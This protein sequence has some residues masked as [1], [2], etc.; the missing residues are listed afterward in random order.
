MAE[1]EPSKWTY[2]QGN[3][4]SGADKTAY[5]RVTSDQPEHLI[6]GLLLPKDDR[7]LGIVPDGVCPH[8]AVWCLVLDEKPG[9]KLCEKHASKLKRTLSE[10]LKGLAFEWIREA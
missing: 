9:A 10:N 4:P 3:G 7:W 6:D 8:L 2:C 5:R 1:R